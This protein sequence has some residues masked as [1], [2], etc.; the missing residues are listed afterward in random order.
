MAVMAAS[1]MVAHQP[2][3]ARER[4]DVG[5]PG[6]E[7]RELGADVE[8]LALDPDHRACA[9]AHPQPPVTGGKKATSSPGRTGSP[10]C[11]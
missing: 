5:A 1:A 7:R 8:G 11:A 4:A 6:G 9:P 2:D 10:G 3:E